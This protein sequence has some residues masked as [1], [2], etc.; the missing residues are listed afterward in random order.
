[1]D[2]R[3]KGVGVDE[4][5]VAYHFGTTSD[6]ER[7]AI[8]EHLLS[9][10]RCL[11]NYLRLKHHLD[12]E[13]RA[14]RPSSHVRERLRAEV[15]AVVGSPPPPRSPS[16]PRSSPPSSPCP[17]RTRRRRRASPTNNRSTPRGRARRARTSTNRE[18][19]MRFHPYFSS[20][21]AIALVTGCAQHAPGPSPGAS[22]SSSAPPASVALAPQSMDPISKSNEV[23]ITPPEKFTDGQRA[24][25]TVKAALLSKYP[26]TTFTE[27]DVWR[28]ATRGLLEHID[29][30]RK[31]WNKLLSPSE[32][33]ALHADLNGEIVGIGVMVDHDETTGYDAI[34]GVLPDSPAEKAGVVAGDLI[35]SVDGVL[36]KGKTEQQ[37]VGAIR[38]KA[39][40]ALKLVLLR[41]DKLLDLSI[42]RAVVHWQEV[43][44]KDL[45]NG[46]DG[47]A[48]RAFGDKT[49]EVLRTTLQGAAQRGVRGVVLDLRGDQ[50]G[51]FEAAV[52]SAGL[53]L[54][55]GT[56]I[57]KLKKRDEEKVFTAKGSVLPNVPM[58]VL[59]D[60]DT[61]SGAELVTAAL[62]EAKRA[63]IVG[64]KTFG[65]WTVQSLD[66]L[67]NGYAAKYTIGL[68]ITPGGQSYEGV[69]V[70]PD[71]TVSATKDK[72]KCSPT[73]SAAELLANDVQLR[74]A[75]ALL[76]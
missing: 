9:C 45:G 73:M 28:A 61:A 22:P 58:V 48:I 4:L 11:R 51:S 38:G 52:E 5:L 44:E 31:K 20:V 18:A 7:E 41:G 1:M 71:L 24:F 17:S 2:C 65:K 8:D 19:A 53:F 30:K 35:V 60:G 12:G 68:F 54:P 33:A 63:R 66:T 59:V 67:P 40:E 15:D 6:E 32:L 43:T 23:E 34:V 50:G 27:D 64:E 14:L 74:T 55:E 21:F 49:P 75:V 10:S 47:I 16:P 13:A 46:I 70:E 37:I 42:V 69:G 25:D 76:Q 3:L 36:F 29:A 56:P 62:R 39:G 26:D 57:V 72:R